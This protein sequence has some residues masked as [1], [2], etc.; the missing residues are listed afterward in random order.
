MATSKKAVFGTKC[1]KTLVFCS[2]DPKKGQILTKIR[3]GDGTL[4][5]VLKNPK[6]FLSQINKISYNQILISDDAYKNN[7]SIQ[8]FTGWNKDV[9]KWIGKMYDKKILLF[10]V[11]IDTRRKLI[12]RKI[13][14]TRF[15]KMVFLFAK[16]ALAK[17]VWIANKICE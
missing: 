14:K 9:L 10:H 12:F 6:K 11:E 5:K 15:S 2:F 4:W 17:V 1:L 16:N 3:G 13:R 7:T 8:H